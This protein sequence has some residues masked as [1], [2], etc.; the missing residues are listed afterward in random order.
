MPT[1]IFTI[2]MRVHVGVA[3][4]ISCCQGYHSQCLAKAHWVCYD[5]SVELRRL[6]DLVG[7][8]DPV[9]ETGNCELSRDANENKTRKEGMFQKKPEYWYH[10]PVLDRYEHLTIL[11]IVPGL[12]QLPPR[13]SG[14]YFQNPSLV[15]GGA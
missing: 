12:C 14:G 6:F 3:V 5:A 9:N 15:R 10:S 11:T 4:P 8:G 13:R 1:I 2:T 7:I